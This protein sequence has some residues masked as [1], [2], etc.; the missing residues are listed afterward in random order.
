MRQLII[1]LALVSV[2]LIPAHAIAAPDA[3]LWPRW[4]KNN[5]ESVDTVDH[6]RWNQLLQRYVVSA[7]DGINRFAYHQVSADDRQLLA[8]YLAAL[9]ATPVSQL[10]RDQQL[11]FW[12][13]LYN[14]LTVQVI[15]K[16]Y[17]V[18]SIRDIRSGFFSAGPWSLKLISIEGEA[19]TLDDIEHR[20]LRPIWKD[21]RIHYAVNC[22]SL[23]CPNLQNRAFSAENSQSLLDRGAREFI[24]HPRAARVD[25]DG[26]L[27]L[28]SI[29]DWFEDDFGNEAGVIAHLKQYA[30]LPLADALKS[31]NE[32]DS[33]HYDWALNGLPGAVAN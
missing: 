29:Y 18:D 11:P 7:K 9:G 15:L 25:E 13:N 16:N 30:A 14:A 24:N 27:Q 1:Y 8:D 23:G 21:P 31:I 28:S 2:L 20:I 4:S 10:S 26:D 17:P 6:G 33:Y 3:E 32:V 12:I 19:L 5:S 22:A